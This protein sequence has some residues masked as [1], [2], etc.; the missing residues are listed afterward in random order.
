[1][2]TKKNYSSLSEIYKEIF[3]GYIP[4]KAFRDFYW[5]AEDRRWKTRDDFLRFTKEQLLA[6]FGEYAMQ[7]SVYYKWNN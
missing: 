1:M 3:S 6:L 2:A 5:W 4:E 7:Q